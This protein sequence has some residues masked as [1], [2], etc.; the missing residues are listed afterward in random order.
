M[1][2][3]YDTQKKN[4]L[5]N[6]VAAPLPAVYVMRIYKYMPDGRFCLRAG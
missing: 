1:L 3:W 4:K 5:E 2:H 6:P